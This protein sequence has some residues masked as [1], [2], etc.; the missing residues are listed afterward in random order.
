M[1]ETATLPLASFT[2]L[3]RLAQTSPIARACIEL[4]KAQV[5]SAEWD[6]VPTPEAAAAMRGDH[7]AMRDFGERRMQA[8]RWFQRPDA[9]YG[10]FGSWLG[11]ALEDVLATDSLAI[12]LRKSAEPGNG[13]LGSDVAALDLVDGATLLP[14]AD[15]LIQYAGNVRRVT[16]TE[17]LAGEGP[18]ADAAWS[19][20]WEP[21]QVLYLPFCRRA[22]SPF[23]F[24]PLERSLVLR[25]GTDEWDFEGAAE[26][27]PAAFGLDRAALGII[28]SPGGPQAEVTNLDARIRGWLKGIFDSILRDHMGVPDLEWRWEE[29][30]HG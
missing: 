20:A 30:E 25:P 24:S 27:M 7:K 4:R 1:T 9:D 10:S 13:L 21:G 29:P 26:R 2:D 8:V 28:A 18:P 15:G 14:L 19:H 11:T 23:G 5:R 3:R 6:I 12:Y 17:M 16:T 22:D